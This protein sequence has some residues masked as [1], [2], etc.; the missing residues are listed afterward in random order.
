MKSLPSNAPS[1]MCTIPKNH[2]YGELS[3]VD[4][5]LVFETHKGNAQW[6]NKERCGRGALTLKPR[7]Q[8]Q[9]QLS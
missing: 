7:L 4:K 3:K 5:N 1:K 9:C 8:D 2:R 6:E